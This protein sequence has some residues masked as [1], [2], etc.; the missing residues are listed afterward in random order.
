M[1]IFGFVFPNAKIYNTSNKLSKPY[2]ILEIKVTA[3][4]VSTKL[5][6]VSEIENWFWVEIKFGTNLGQE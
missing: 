2:R 4:I 1:S 3:Q 5:Y 6:G